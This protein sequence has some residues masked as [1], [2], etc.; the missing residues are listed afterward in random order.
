[1]S[2]IFELTPTFDETSLH[3]FPL[4]QEGWHNFLYWVMVVITIITG[5]DIPVWTL[6]KFF[7]YYKTNS[8]YQMVQNNNSDDK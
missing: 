7:K 1:M 6:S 8:L 5:S 4:Q 2:S 3:T